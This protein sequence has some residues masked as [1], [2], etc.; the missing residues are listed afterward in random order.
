MTLR[1]IL[2]NIAP[3]GVTCAWKRRR[4]GIIE[5][6]PLFHYPG[7]GKRIRRIVKF[8]LPYCLVCMV[9][10]SYDGV[11]VERL[12]E[13]RQSLPSLSECS[14]TAL[15]P[16]V[17][18]IAEM[19]I[20]QCKLYR[21]DQKLKMLDLLGVDAVA[22]A[23]TDVIA[24][25]REL[26][27]ATLV[28][29]YRVPYFPAVEGLYK[30]A[31]R[32]GLRIGFDVDDLIFDVEKYRPNPNILKMSAKDVD[33]L[34]QGA[35][36]YR[37]SLEAA[38]FTIASTPRLSECMRAF[39]SGSAYVLPNVHEEDSSRKGFTYPLGT[40]D[41]I[42]IGYGSGTLTHDAD[43]E[44]CAKAVLR[45]LEHYPQTILAVHG[46]LQLPAE[47]DGLKDR[48]RR[49]EFVPFSEY[50]NAI[51][52]FDINLAPLAD[53]VFNDCK[54]NIK[55]IEAAVNRVPTVASPSAEFAAAI[56]D[57]ENG[58]LAK[59]EA[60]WYGALS[61][62]VES[63]AL[64]RKMGEAAW[65][66]VMARYE[67][68]P[69]AQD[70]M[71]RILDAELPVPRAKSHKRILCVNVL[72]APVSFG[73]ATIVGEKLAKALSAA[74][75]EVGVFS[76]DFMTPHADGAVLRY[77]HEGQTCFLRDTV[78]RAD[79]FSNWRNPAV[80]ETFGQVLDAFHPDV[81]HLHSI[82]VVGF[83][84]CT[85]CKERGIPY[86]ITAH[87]AWWLCPR[88]FMLDANGRSCR[89]H[90]HGVDLYRCVECTGYR[91]LFL[92]WRCLMEILNGA[93]AVLAPSDFHRDLYVRSGVSESLIHTNMN[94]VAVPKSVPPHKLQKVLTFAYLGGKCEHKGY[95]MLKRVVRNLHGDYRL[96]LVDI[97]L[98]FGRGKINPSEWPE[99]RKVECLKPFDAEDVDEFYSGID[100]LL[101]PSCCQESFGLTVREALA[102]NVW[103]ISTNAGG[104]IGRDLLS[105]ENGDLVEI[106][107]EV[108]FASAMQRL[109]D[110]PER[111]NGFVNPYRSGITTVE[112]QVKELLAI[113]G[114]I[115]SGR[116]SDSV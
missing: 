2:K 21:V 53:N 22:V 67:L 97:S 75:A 29:F 24:A 81:V 4:Y 79:A 52:R 86:V 114:E 91:Q 56:K 38:D 50:R 90:G 45:V 59:D 87:D 76:V 71:R 9:R 108:G 83:E 115:D 84:I 68:R 37:K 16:R 51:A 64:R 82:Q 41:E 25:M 99:R 112:Q 20:P 11:S 94:G 62:L 60:G 10:R 6:Q 54:S 14:V 32:L 15:K 78:N 12:L 88:Q 105:G 110:A 8:S 116:I 19:S 47:F 49:V 98:R 104:D 74:G 42:V 17:L 33:G 58:C 61:R 43:F 7:W 40:R 109:I 30:E 46:M 55:F 36:F 57:G 80:A 3:Y 66:T 72:Y 28:I 27:F 35:R 39:N 100:V 34:M 89:R 77:E 44:C 103:V 92:R 111:L 106:G 113:Y 31:R 18:I 93:A 102:R 69:V 13:S 101:L 95:Y 73:G 1:A 26:Q 96:V 5:D 70:A 107:D 23:W 63:E 65:R 48:I 85:I